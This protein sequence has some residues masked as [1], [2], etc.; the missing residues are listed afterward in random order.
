[1]A[2]MRRASTQTDSFL[3]HLRSLPY[4]NDVQL[5]N[6]VGNQDRLLDLRT[7]K[8]RFSFAIELR[9]TY[10][11]R[12]AT[13]AL[14][15]SAALPGKPPPIVFARYIPRPTGERLAAAGI[16]FVDA[17]GNLN[18]HLGNNYQTRLL[19]QRETRPAPE[20]KRIGAAT[21]Q[22][23][24]TFLAS[25]EA[26]QSP[27]RHLAELAGVSK[28][29]ASDGRQRLVA[30]G[31][32]RRQGA[33]RYHL[34]DANRLEER[35]LQGYS[36]A[37]RPHLHLARM[38]G[39]DRA[40]DAFVERLAKVA[41]QEGIPWALTG[42]TGAYELDRFYRGEET[43]VFIPNLTKDLQR[44][45]KLLPDRQGPITFLR[46]FSPGILWPGSTVHPV[47]HP[48]LLYAELLQQE[49]ARALEAAKEIQTRYL[50]K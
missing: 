50:R 6:P 14:L 31:I 9:R 8:G 12:T 19:G 46:M 7:P 23:F 10:L 2:D 39:A 43:I 32:L 16:N 4:V 40:P 44:Q 42:G 35:F 13:N 22:V 49:D 3:E 48:W 24:F 30:E 11:D 18:L 25:P 34:A 29:A 45:L 37:L 36:R 26:I 27:A 41:K 33:R 15:A 5:R 28:T 1:M 38:R 20:A 47:A 17:A 21:V